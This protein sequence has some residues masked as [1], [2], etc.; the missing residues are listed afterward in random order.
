MSAT[1]ARL[2]SRR[3]TVM[4]VLLGAL[5]MLISSVLT[6]VHATGLGDTAALDS[7][8]LNGSE[9]AAIAQAMGLVGAAAA[10]AASLARLVMG[11]IIAVLLVV[12]GIVG[13][14]ASINVLIDP[15]AASL[16]ALAEIT[17]TTEIAGNYAPGL[18]LWVCLIGG[19]LV[20]VSAAGMLIFSHRWPQGARNRR[21][22]PGAAVDSEDLDEFDLWDGLSQGEDPTENLAQLK[23]RTSDDDANH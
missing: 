23:S 17:G 2:S 21:Y 22:Q 4:L 3:S 12:A 18:G 7:Y 20:L 10:I 19:L 11:R 5:L 1:A 8:D 13:V 16:S 15:A 14:V 9:V 6:W